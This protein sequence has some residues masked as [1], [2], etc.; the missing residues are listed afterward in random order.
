MEYS[1]WQAT[2][3]ASAFLLPYK[4]QIIWSFAALLFTATITLSIGQGVRLLIDQ[5]IA[6]A[7]PDQLRQYVLI[8]MGLAVAL[9]AGTYLPLL[10]SYLSHHIPIHSLFIFF[11]PSSFHFPIFDLI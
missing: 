6:T 8:F 9:A 10:L 4:R 1:R 7:S 2:R 3:M 11:I 5:G